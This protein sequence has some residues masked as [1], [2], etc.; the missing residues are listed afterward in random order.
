MVRNLK[1]FHKC[2]YKVKLSSLT[3]ILFDIVLKVLAN[4][5]RQEKE[6]KGIRIVT[7]GLELSLFTDDMV[8]EF[9]NKKTF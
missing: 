3:P 1:H 4:S 2:R 6:I 5:T 7:K 9:N 8:L